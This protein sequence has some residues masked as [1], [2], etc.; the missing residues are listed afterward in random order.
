MCIVTVRVFHSA[1][2]HG[3]FIQYN[4]FFI[5]TA[6]HNSAKAPVTQWQRLCEMRGRCIEFYMHIGLRQQACIA[7]TEKNDEE[8][9]FELFLHEFFCFDG[10]RRNALEQRNKLNVASLLE[11]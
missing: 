2:P 8:I 1:R 7:E 10:V 6:K 11:K 3:I 9:W 4:S 5:K